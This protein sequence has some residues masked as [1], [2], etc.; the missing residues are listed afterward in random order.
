M[1]HDDIL[2]A[3][4]AHVYHHAPLGT[5]PHPSAPS[6][7]HTSPKELPKRTFFDH[8]HAASNLVSAGGGC[9]PPLTTKAVPHGVDGGGGGS[10]EVRRLFDGDGWGV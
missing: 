7:P 5:T 1:P 10:G 8:T 6:S 3:W 9:D 2:A 4:T